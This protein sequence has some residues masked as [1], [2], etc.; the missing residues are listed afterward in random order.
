[1]TTLVNLRQEASLL[2]VTCFAV[3]AETGATNFGVELALGQDESFVASSR[4]LFP[5]L[6]AVSLSRVLSIRL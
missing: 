4:L 2:D 6:L 5:C 1:M 3:L